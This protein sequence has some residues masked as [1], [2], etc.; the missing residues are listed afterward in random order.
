MHYQPYKNAPGEHV[1]GDQ[2]DYHLQGEYF[3]LV[4]ASNAAEIGLCMI[5]HL[6]FQCERACTTNCD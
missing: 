6:L 5:I 1:Q 2:L 4:R 3:Q